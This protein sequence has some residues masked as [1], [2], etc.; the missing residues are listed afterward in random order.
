LIHQKYGYFFLKIIIGSRIQK[1]I[2]A[3]SSLRVKV[4]QIKDFGKV[5]MVCGKY[6]YK[7]KE[8]IRDLG[9]NWSDAGLQLGRNSA[10]EEIHLPPEILKKKT[11]VEIDLPQ[12][13]RAFYLL[14]N[15]KDD[16]LQELFKNFQ[17]EFDIHIFCK[18]SLKFDNYMNIN[19]RGHSFSQT[20]WPRVKLVM[21]GSVGN[22]L[23][24]LGSQYSN[25]GCMPELVRDDDIDLLAYQVI[26]KAAVSY[27]KKQSRKHRSN[28]RPIYQVKK[29]P[30]WYHVSPRR[31]KKGDILTP[32]RKSSGSWGPKDFVYLNNSPYPHYTMLKTI[33]N[34]TER[35]WHVYEVEPLGKVFMGE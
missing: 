1:N 10:V 17:R 6:T 2:G 18:H 19:H 32:L 5:I 7:I 35:S 23:K 21:Q 31:L 34:D 26:K 4:Y 30:V 3:V 33:L 9:G 11:Q 27:I 16:Q 25:K 15:G 8:L 29:Q 14:S 12:Y 20:P 24:A 22:I 28:D 13:S